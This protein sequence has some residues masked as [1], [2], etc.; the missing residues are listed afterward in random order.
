MTIY[1]QHMAHAATV[2]PAVPCNSNTTAIGGGCF[3]CLFDP[4]EAAVVPVAQE[5]ELE[6]SRE[7]TS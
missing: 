2:R 3:N 6:H 7:V 1:E 4:N 5:L